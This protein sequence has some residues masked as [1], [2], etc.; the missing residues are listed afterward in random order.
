MR[1]RGLCCPTVSVRP[2]VRLSVCL[3]LCL[4]VTLVHCIQT[5]EDIVKLLSRPDSPASVPNFKENP[6]SVGT[7]YKGVGKFCD[8]RLKSPSISETVPY[9]IGP[10]LLWNIN[11][12][13]AVL[14]GDIF[15]DLDR[16]LTRF[17][18]SRHF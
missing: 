18:R 17:S 5:V 3:S 4:S 15:N 1:K 10:W 2:S 9:E 16:P 8:F 14:N 13:C 12:K 6:F 11:R 7:K